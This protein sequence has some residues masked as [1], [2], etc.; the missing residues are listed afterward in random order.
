[1][2]LGRIGYSWAAVGL[3]GYYTLGR[4]GL[5]I[6]RLA[7]G[8]M[9][10]GQMG[11]GCDRE[12]A[13]ALFDQYLEA[14][15]NFVDTADRYAD[16]AAEEI[17]GEFVAERRIRDYIVLATKFSLGSVQGNP[18]SG[19]NG[20]KS[21]MR[22]LEGSLRRLGTDYVDLYYL[23]AWDA[24]TPVDEVVG[25]LDDLVS[26]GKVRYVAFSDV[27]GW[28]A[29]RGHTLAE[30][31]GQA[32][33]IALQLEYSLA[34]RGIEY[35]LTAAAQEL[36][37]GIVAW[38]PLA[39]GLLSGKYA[40]ADEVSAMA[41]GRLKIAAPFTP[42]EL[43]KL[44]ERNWGTVSVLQEVAEALGRPPAQVAINWVA[45]RPAVAA[46]LLGATRPEQ[47]EVTLQSL[48][49]TLPDE[50]RDRLDEV[51]RPS[52]EKPYGWFSWG[53]GIMNGGMR[54]NEHSYAP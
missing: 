19:G 30:L 8:T 4:S 39:N 54:R 51:S 47:L 17:I 22:A 6:S 14:G 10:F 45:S 18:N 9:T 37:M 48:D 46:V 3:D 29:A 33:P 23:H 53:H 13:G 20:R 7:L 32:L 27:P 16:G 1:M 15:G 31:R 42:P 24:F 38:G 2:A 35:E 26:E 36:G 11:W 44:T 40:P 12:V 49:F 5:R 21:M 34:E 50:L 25:A 52:N 28:Y 41:D 43:D